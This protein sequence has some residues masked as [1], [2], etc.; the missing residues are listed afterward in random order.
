MQET[1][2]LGGHLHPWGRCDFEANEVP[3]VHRGLKGHRAAMIHQTKRGADTEETEREK[4]R[5]RET[6]CFSKQLA[7][8][9]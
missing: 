4:M 5:E 1:S 2:P 6:L 8:L 9:Q 7:G 3:T